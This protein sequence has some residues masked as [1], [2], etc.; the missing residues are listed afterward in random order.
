[1]V[2]EARAAAGAATNTV[3]GQGLARAFLT[4]G[5]LSQAEAITSCSF[6]AAVW[7]VR[8]HYLVFAPSL[9]PRAQ[10]VA[11][12]LDSTVESIPIP[13]SER[14]GEKA[15]RALAIDPPGGA[16]A[17]YSDGSALGNPGPTG[18]GFVVKQGGVTLLSDAIPLGLGDNNVG[19]TAALGAI[20]Q[21]RPKAQVIQA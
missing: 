19:E 6:L 7:R 21:R 15:T 11:R 3:L 20:F 4:E 18:A 14:K 9:Q 1:M 13:G 2:G 10:V 16:I 12:I 17:G 8:S 5:S